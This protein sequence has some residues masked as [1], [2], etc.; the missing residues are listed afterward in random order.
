MC[1]EEWGARSGD[2]HCPSSSWTTVRVPTFL[3][4]LQPYPSHYIAWWSRILK[5]VG[6][7]LSSSVA[8]NQRR[9]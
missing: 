9:Q 6:F 4:F 5:A 2:R 1:T 7:T 8:N 3:Q